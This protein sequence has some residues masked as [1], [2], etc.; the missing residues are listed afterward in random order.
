MPTYNATK[1]KD[2]DTTTPT[3]GVGNS[4]IPE[5]NDA[6]REIKTVIKNQYAVKTVTANYTATDADSIIFANATAG[7][8]TVTLLQQSTVSSA[9]HIK[10]YT[11]I[12]TDSSANA[13]TV[14]VYTGETINGSASVSFT[15]Q[16]YGIT[17]IGNGGTDWKEKRGANAYNAYNAIE[18]GNKTN[19]L[20]TSDIFSD[21]VVTGLLGLD[22][23]VSLTMTT[24]GGTA[25][26]TGKR[27]VKSSSDSDLTYTY[28]ASNDTYD[29]LKND[30]TIVHQSVA[31]G[32]AEPA[33]PA[34]TIKL[35]KVVTNATEIT[36]VTDLR[37]LAGMTA[38]QVAGQ[39]RIPIAGQD[40]KLSSGW[41]TALSFIRDSYRN[42]TISNNAV[43]P[44]YQLDITADEVILQD[45]SSPVQAIRASSVSKSLGITGSGVNGLDTGTEAASTWYHIWCIGKSDGTIDT[46]LSLS[47]TAPTMPTGYT[48]KAYLG[49]IYNDAASNFITINQK[50]HRVSMGAVQVLSNGTA[51]AYT[52]ISLTTAIPT[53]AKE[54]YL[55]CALDNGTSGNLSRI[56][57]VAKTTGELGQ[58]VYAA[59]ISNAG[60]SQDGTSLRMP[61]I[62]PQS[63]YYLMEGVATPKVVSLSIIGWEY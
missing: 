10:E 43:N 6:V 18:V 58:V 16:G 15:T 8:I 40:G 2:L 57:L 55:K 9:T 59:Y 23:G 41:F 42:L 24:P 45:T 20:V 48:Y 27:I 63:I 60:V 33:Q 25:Y 54:I 5:L 61:I 28:P 1:V 29:Y 11:V 4:Y 30:G 36:S 47:A 52:L 51:T 22:P 19:A 49:A 62:E 21:F 17:I 35:Q 3:E 50:D 56:T 44:T 46:L 31:N 7:A 53:T 12:K 39:N 37:P 14:A 38:S 26:V 13:V 32:A 34:N